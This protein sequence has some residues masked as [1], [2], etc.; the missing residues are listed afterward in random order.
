MEL[1]IARARGAA[2]YRCERFSS[3]ARLGLAEVATLGRQ[4]AVSGLNRDEL[5]AT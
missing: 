1:R 5:A 3:M 4:S 2:S